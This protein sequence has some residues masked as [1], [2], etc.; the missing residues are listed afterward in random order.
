M[1]A[2]RIAEKIIKEFHGQ[3]V[4]TARMYHYLV[5]EIESHEKT[6]LERGRREAIREIKEYIK[7]I[8]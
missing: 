2:E 6:M 3:K 8:K 7:D 5:I 1:S 4:T